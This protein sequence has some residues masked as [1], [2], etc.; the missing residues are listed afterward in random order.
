MKKNK[1]YI[2]YCSDGASR[3]ILFYSIETNLER[4]PPS[5]VIYDGDRKEI[6]EKLIAIFRNDLLLIKPSTLDEY[7]LKK[8]NGYTSDFI[9]NQMI[10]NNVAHLL[11]FGKRILKKRLIDAFPKTLINFHPSLLPSFKGLNAIDQA[12]SKGVCFLGNTVHYINN[13]IDEGQII[14]Q[15]AMYSSD[16]SDYEDVLE[17]QFPLLKIILRDIL[18]YSINDNEIIS[19]LINREKKFFLKS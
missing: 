4:F 18:K 6:E 9:L 10:K 19:E 5:K 15:I 11:C 12:I 14:K 3:V 1:P 8:I 17:L 7:E 16:F 2:I 13:E